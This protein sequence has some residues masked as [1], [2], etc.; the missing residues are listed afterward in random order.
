[1]AYSNIHLVTT[2]TLSELH[3]IYTQKVQVNIYNFF[4]LCGISADICWTF[5]IDHVSMAEFSRGCWL[6]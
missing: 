6:L 5:R 1:M 2:H 3:C 4:E